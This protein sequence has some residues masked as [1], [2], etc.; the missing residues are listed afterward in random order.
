MLN[1]SDMIQ[2]STNSLLRI[3]ISSTDQI[4]QNL[5]SEFLIIKAKNSGISGATAFKGIIGYGASSA[6]QSYKF[7]EISDKLPV[8]VEIIDEDEKI[9]SFYDSI[10]PELEKMRY[11][12]LVTLEK[13]EVLLFKSGK[14][15]S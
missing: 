2:N 8:V 1:L 10:L 15:K 5:L 11:G 7:W 14:T 12:C 6:I 13:V 4:K 9:R 3:F